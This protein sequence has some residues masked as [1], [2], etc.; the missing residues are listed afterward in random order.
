MIEGV[1]PHDI[2]TI[3][4]QDGVIIHRSSLRAAGD[5]SILCARDR[6]GVLAMYATRCEI[7]ALVGALRRVHAVF[8]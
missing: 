5:G 3:V 8:S 6:A 1:H 2:G 4:D 7:D